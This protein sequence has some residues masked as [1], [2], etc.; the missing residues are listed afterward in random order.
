MFMLTLIGVLLLAGAVYLIIEAFNTYTQKEA[1]YRFFTIEHTIAMV[2][3]YG[4]LW[5]GYSIFESSGNDPLNGIILMI[6]GGV[7]LCFVM[8]NNFKMTPRSIAIKGS[9]MQLVFYVPIA[10]AII[11]IVYM[12][13]A[14]F[15]QTKP[16]YSI[17]AR[18]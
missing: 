8:V 17:N 9:A 10:L 7:V 12:T 6:I 4:L 15:S 16:V 13:L 11:P 1:K 2:I 3:S 5:I 14:F 18:D